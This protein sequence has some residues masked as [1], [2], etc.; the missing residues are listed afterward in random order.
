MCSGLVI[1]ACIVSTL[2]Q[3]VKTP[4]FSN[5]HRSPHKIPALHINI[6]TDLDRNAS[7]SYNTYSNTRSALMSVAYS[8]AQKVR[9]RITLDISAFPDFDPHQIDW[10]KL[11]KL[12]PA[13]KCE[14]YVEDLSTPDRW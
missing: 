14:A 13:E 4:A 8:Q 10:D 6:P 3:N 9:Y 7:A 12:E 2:S 5:P 1:F 11:F